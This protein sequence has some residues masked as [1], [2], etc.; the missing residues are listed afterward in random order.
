MNEELLNWEREV[1]A[2]HRWVSQGEVA[3][4]EHARLRQLY[5]SAAPFDEGCQDLIEQIVALEICNWRLEESLLAL[6]EAIGSK[7]PVPWEIG[8]MASVTQER[9]DRIWAYY[10]SLR[11]WLA[12]ASTKPRGAYPSLLAKCDPDGEVG[13]HVREMLGERDELKELRVERLCLHLE[14]WLEGLPGDDQPR[15]QALVAA[16]AAI[17][18]ETES[19]APNDEFEHQERGFAHRTRLADN[20]QLFPCHHKLFRRYD[21]LISSIG[22]AKWRGVMPYRGTDGFQRA[23]TLEKYLAPI[24]AWLDGGSATSKPGDSELAA[25]IHDLLG[26]RDDAKVFLASL[27][28]SLLHSQQIIARQWAEQAAKRAHQE[29]AGSG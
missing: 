18:A 19:R 16:A 24:T 6:C 17:D 13:R 29:G 15:K 27:L 22:C 20:G 21:I 28:V 10:L 4:K 2:Q 9:W 25:K 8:H 5:D 23:E 7:R 26:E 14:F 1:L 3:K 12:E 11:E